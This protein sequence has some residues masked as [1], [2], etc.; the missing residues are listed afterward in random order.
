MLAFIHQP[1][2][3]IN[4]GGQPLSEELEDTM[5]KDICSWSLSSR[6]RVLGAGKGDVEGIHPLECKLSERLEARA[7]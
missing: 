1:S 7:F 3:L 5:M 4:P 6:S 2:L